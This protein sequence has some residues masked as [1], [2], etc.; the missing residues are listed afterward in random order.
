LATLAARLEWVASALVKAVAAPER[1]EARAGAEDRVVVAKE[2]TAAARV[3]P[4]PGAQAV[5]LPLARRERSA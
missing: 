1:L 4:E 5:P 2:E 3:R